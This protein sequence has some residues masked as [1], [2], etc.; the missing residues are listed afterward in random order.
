[1]IYPRSSSR[2]SFFKRI[3]FKRIEFKRIEFKRIKFKRV[4]VNY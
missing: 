2:V 3:E 1:M 4:L